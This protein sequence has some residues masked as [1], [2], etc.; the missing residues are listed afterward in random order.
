MVTPE[1]LVGI[2]R[3]GDFHLAEHLTDND[4]DVLVVDF[5]ALD[6]VN[7][8]DLVDQVLLEFLGSASFEQIF[9]RHGAFGDLIATFD[10]VAIG[11]NDV[12]AH[13]DKVVDLLTGLGVSDDDLLLAADI[14]AEGNDAFDLGDDA[15]VLGLAG[16]EKLGHPW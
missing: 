10:D 8:L 2:A 7:R 11:N 4:L 16:F 9:R 1:E 3:V 12:L 13:R 14:A 5:H 15:G 6:A